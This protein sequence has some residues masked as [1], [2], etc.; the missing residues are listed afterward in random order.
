[1]QLGPGSN[2]CLTTADPCLP[3]IAWKCNDAYFSWSS[4][5]APSNLIG[6]YIFIYFPVPYCVALPKKVL[7]K[8]DAGGAAAD[9]GQRSHNDVAKS[10]NHQP[11]IFH[12]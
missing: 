11:L 7:G 1:M 5:L 6:Q 8:Q 4:Q 2:I 12:Y 10:F 9:R 3:I